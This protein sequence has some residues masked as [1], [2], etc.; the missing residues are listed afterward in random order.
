MFRFTIRELV[1]LTLVVAMG[2]GLCLRPVSAS[3]TFAA[4]ESGFNA[5]AVVRVAV[6]LVDREHLSRKSLDHKQSQR[7]FDAFL[8]ALDPMRM[9]FLAEDIAEFRKYAN[10]LD[11]FAKSGDFHF[12]EVVRLRYRER[13]AQAAALAAKH[14]AVEPDFS[15]DEYLPAEFDEYANSQKELEERWRLR[16]KFEQ[17]IE[18]GGRR[19][20]DQVRDQLLRRYARI[21]KSAREMTEERL[22]EVYLKA[23]LKSYD[24]HSDY[25]SPGSGTL[26]SGGHIP[27]RTL[28]LRLKQKEGRIVIAGVNPA[29][30]N[31]DIEWL[32]G[33]QLVAISRTNGS[34]FDLVEISLDEVAQ[35][36]MSGTNTLDSDSEVIL[37]LFNP[38]TLERRSQQWTRYVHKF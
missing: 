14:L 6:E 26:Y 29:I 38:N 18:K 34:T 11:G 13:T 25:F 1:L 15:V 24:P 21:A 19:S 31:A 7:W 4:Q 27:S 5:A 23:L 20:T 12:A 8:A 2:G 28:G 30:G 16:I 10:Q 37:E 36:I 3:E 32:I 33:W 35:M 22:C 9:Y 17:L